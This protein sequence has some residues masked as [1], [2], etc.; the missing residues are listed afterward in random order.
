MDLAPDVAQ[1][2]ALSAERPAWL[3]RVNGWR[4]ASLV[5]FA[6]VLVLSLTTF[7]DYGI[8][9]DDKV[10][11]EYGEHILAYYESGFTDRTAV[12]PNEITDDGNLPYYGG[13]FDLLSALVS[14]GSPLSIYFSRHLL[15][16]FV[17]MVGLLMVWRLGERLGGPRTGFFALALLATVPAYYGH[18]FMNPKDIPF[19]VAM[20]ALLAAICAVLDEWPRPRWRTA[21]W[22]GTAAGIALGTRVGAVVAG[23]N[24]AV[25]LAVWMLLA[26]RRAGWWP[27]LAVSAAG[28]RRLLAVLP[29]TWALMVVLW[30]WAALEPLNP[31]RALTM[32]SH[33]PFEGDVTFNGVA[34]PAQD[35]PRSYLPAFLALTLPESV[36]LGLLAAAVG[37]A[38]ALVY[39]WRRP[40]ALSRRDLQ[41]MAVATAALFPLV[42]FLV[43]RPTA[44]NGM[45]HF[46]FMLPPLAVVAA[47]GIDAVWRGVEAAR[48]PVVL[49]VAT[50]FIGLAAIRMVSLHPYEYTYYNDLFGGLPAAEGR[51]DMDYWGL[52]VAKTTRLLAK[53]LKAEGDGSPAHPWRVA[54]EAEPTSAELFMPRF[55]TIGDDDDH[56]DFLVALCPCQRPPGARLMAETERQGVILS[57]AYD[58][59]PDATAANTAPVISPGAAPIVPTH[60]PGARSERHRAFQGLAAQRLFGRSD[61][62]HRGEHRQKVDVKVGAGRVHPG[63]PAVAAVE[64]QRHADQQATVADARSRRTATGGSTIPQRSAAGQTGGQ[65]VRLPHRSQQG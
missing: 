51:F 18:M 44:Y 60:Q 29:L 13:S 27:T 35:L 21:L 1:P 59:R 8:S 24:L 33:F 55:M 23:F 57:E 58:L 15:G 2:T 36:L 20:V 31:L 47:V 64:H 65:P 12:T 39:R 46:L 32:F 45:R 26:V 50:G 22:L 11:K 62:D 17:G 16:A 19:A 5:L 30:P 41:L 9:W 48:R 49:A 56:P 40:L 4:L 14:H 52:S 37:A 63:D 42:Y 7:R 43:E 10:Q 6:V 53:A 61:R 38:G 3:V 54:T 25:P 34:Y 28:C